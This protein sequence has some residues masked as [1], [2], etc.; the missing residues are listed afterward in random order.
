M[1]WIMLS[2]AA[3]MALSLG[4]AC[5]DKEAKEK[6]SV[7]KG[8]TA[9]AR[10][11]A[12]KKKAH[13]TPA[14]EAAAQASEAEQPKGEESKSGVA[15]EPKSKAGQEAGAKDEAVAEA[16]GT[17]SAATPAA[18]EAPANNEA[19][20]AEAPVV[21]PAD[22]PAAPPLPNPATMG[23]PP[24]T[25]EHLLSIADLV[26][27]I[28]TKGWVTKGAIA[29]RAPD[30]GYNSIQYEKPGTGRVVTLQL[31]KSSREEAI[32]S[33]NNMLATWPNAQAQENMVTQDTFFWNR[34][35]LFGLVFLDT[36][37][38]LVVAVAC[39]TEICTDTQLLQLTL[40]AFGRLKK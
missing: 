30:E 11:K 39:H 1:T 38:G 26:A 13:R 28:H 12:R 34:G 8:S 3:L 22:Q 24:P 6:A 7:K 36:A 10:K 29:G 16:A 40:T 14:E 9:E 19:V 27:V 4:S 32:A 20:K 25:V 31:W 33:W 17:E 18:P 5:S 21:A 37:K 23:P 35:H 2:L 15:E